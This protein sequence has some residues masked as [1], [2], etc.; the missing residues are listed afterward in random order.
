MFVIGFTK[1][2]SQF[3]NR[4]ITDSERLKAKN[5]FETRSVEEKKNEK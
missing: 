3:T 2:R 5:G 4:W 1:K